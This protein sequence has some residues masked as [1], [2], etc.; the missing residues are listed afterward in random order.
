[1]PRLLSSL[2]ADRIRYDSLE[3]RSQVATVKLSAGTNYEIL[4]NSQAIPDL[5]AVVP[6]SVV[7]SEGS[8]YVCVSRALDSATTVEGKEF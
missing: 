6:C 8:M 5:C 3:R 7:I 2:L 1:M 4:S